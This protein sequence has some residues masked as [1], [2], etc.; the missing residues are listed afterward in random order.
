MSVLLSCHDSRSASPGHNLSPRPPSFTSNS[1]HPTREKGEQT[2]I[3]MPGWRSQW[4]LV[5]LN[6][7]TCG[8]EICVAAGITY[9]PPLLLEAGVE[10]RYMTMVLG[11]AW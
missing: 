9:V 4:H 10:E 7:L 6:S 11:K 1:G 8:L 5:L 3:N 2:P